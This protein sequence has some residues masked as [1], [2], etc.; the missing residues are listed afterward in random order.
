MELLLL[1][2]LFLAGGFLLDGS[3]DETVQP[4]GSA[5]GTGEDEEESP[6]TRGPGTDGDDLIT[7]TD[8]P[9][10]LFGLEGDDTIEGGGRPDELRGDT[11]IAG[12]AGGNDLI[13]GGSGGDVISG[14]GGDD[15]L[16]G[17]LGGDV[18]IGGTGDDK[19]S[20]GRGADRLNGGDGNDTL[21]GG[22]GN[23]TLDDLPSGGGDD[24]LSGGEG[25]D[26]L[27]G[28]AGFDT[29]RGGAGDDMLFDRGNGEDGAP[30]PSRIRG[31]A[32]DDTLSFDGGST[33]SGN[34]GDDWFTF[35]DVLGDDNVTFIRDF[36]AARDTLTIDIEVDTADGAE[37]RLETW[38]DGE[39]ADLFYG[40]DLIAEIRGGQDLDV[41]DV[42][43]VLTLQE[44]AAPG[45]FTDGDTGIA[46]K[47]NAGD[48]EIDGGGGDDNIDVAG[49]FPFRGETGADLVLGGEGDDA[50]TGSGG[51]LFEDRILISDIISETEIVRIV[52]TD[53]LVGGEGDDRLVSRAGAVL[54]GGAGVDVFGVDVVRPVPEGAEALPP[55]QITDFEADTE[56]LVLALP[57]GKDVS[58]ITIEDRPDGTGADILLDGS[59]IAEVTGGAGLVTSDLRFV[60]T[61]ALNAANL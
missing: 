36:N 49:T 50:L 57:T 43:L 45:R 39:G 25:D 53:T 35:S 26:L 31:G 18:I 52:E 32:G 1:L 17:Q 44:D 4:A 8:S 6:D 30:E 38:D 51:L 3:D 19:L 24:L 40:D 60:R 37:L 20:G 41:E 29:L 33:V 9:D 42:E 55:T 22:K 12:V 14:E 5:S 58:N 10:T 2:P 28:R 15:T 13:R 54:T 21:L 61:V 23:D 47:G 27:R 46:I 11:G 59:V 48:N 34:E 56:E 7:G 16:R